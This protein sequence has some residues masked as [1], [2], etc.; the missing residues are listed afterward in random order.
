MS[1]HFNHQWV[2]DVL[3]RTVKAVLKLILEVGGNGG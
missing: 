2:L 3:N 1:H